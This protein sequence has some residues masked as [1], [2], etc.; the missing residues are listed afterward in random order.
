LLRY[1]ITDRRSGGWST[2]TLLYHIARNVDRGI[3]YIQIREKDLS[4]RELL[5]LTARAV[6]IATGSRSSIL[7]NDRADVAIAAGAA[8]VHLRAGS[9]PPE[10]LRCAF[11]QSLVIGMSCHS[12]DDIAAAQQADLIVFGP[13]FDTPAKGPAKGLNELAR[14]AAASRVPVLALGGVNR[15][16]FSSCIAAGAAGIAAIRMFQE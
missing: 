12:L 11:A 8:G 1:Y 15:N 2:T 3:E 5:E 13:V 16:N 9:I 4:A 10:R 6:E 14:A 7:V